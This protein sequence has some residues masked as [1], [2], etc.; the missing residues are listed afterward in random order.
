VY[1]EVLC[2]RV[3]FVEEGSGNW[4]KV[5]FWCSGGWNLIGHMFGVS[6]EWS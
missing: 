1:S 5:V 3:N 6:K 2:E 4:G